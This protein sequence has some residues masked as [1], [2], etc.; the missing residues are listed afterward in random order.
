MHEV[1]G[2][3]WQFCPNGKPASAR[4]IT[5]NGTVKQN[6]ENP[7]GKG[8]AGEAARIFPFLPAKLGRAIR[9]RGNI[10]TVFPKE[11]LNSDFDLIALPTKNEWH[12]NSDKELIFKSV[13]KLIDLADVNPWA[14]IVMPRPGCGAGNLNWEMDVKPMIKGLLDD[15]FY[16]ITFE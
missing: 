12:E 16:V 3:L 11:S 1:V 6:G 9:K 8:S 2:N 14:T 7:M 4:V 15:R 13:C 10:V 5:T